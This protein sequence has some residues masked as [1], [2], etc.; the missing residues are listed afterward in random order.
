MPAEGAN[1]QSGRQASKERHTKVSDTDDAIVV[2]MDG[3]LVNID[4]SV[5]RVD[6]D[7]QAADAL[8]QVCCCCLAS[9]DTIAPT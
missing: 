4:V 9:Q 6:P 5:V 1:P 2:W 7:R 8:V 3:G